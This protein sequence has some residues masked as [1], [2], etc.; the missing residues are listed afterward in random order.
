M[1]QGTTQL[2]GH[3]KS[4]RRITTVVLTSPRKEPTT[5]FVTKVLTLQPHHLRMLHATTFKSIQEKRFPNMTVTLN[6]REQQVVLDGKKSDVAAAEEAINDI[7]NSMKSSTLDMSLQLAKLMSTIA[8]TTHM[9]EVLKKK[10]ICA[11]FETVDETTVG[12]YALNDEQLERAVNVIRSETNEIYVEA[13]SAHTLHTHQW[14]A[15]KDQLHS[16]YGDLLAVSESD[17]R[18]TISGTEDS[19]TTAK[20]TLSRLLV[21]NKGDSSRNRVCW[22]YVLGFSTVDVV[23]GDLTKFRADAIVNAANEGLEH[24]GG[25][26][27]AVVTAGI[28]KKCSRK[29]VLY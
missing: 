29:T 16:E 3:S 24:I 17:S 22:S 1:A 6:T 8:M 25:L 13:D 11:V 28:F 21:K 19:V 9:T 4:V 10:D 12:V 27:E 5:P 23:K 26:A 18:V 7:V 15:L 2:K 14:A 20:K